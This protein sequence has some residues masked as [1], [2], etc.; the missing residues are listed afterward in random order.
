[1][2]AEAIKLYEQ[3]KSGQTD[4]IEPKSEAEEYL[5]SIMESGTGQGEGS[6][7]VTEPRSRIEAYLKAIIENGIPGSGSGT[8][9]V[10]I[11]DITIEE[12]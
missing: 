1:M 11:K 8:A 4:S 10:G 2:N 3:L 12:A 6:S 7:G 9:G 5:L